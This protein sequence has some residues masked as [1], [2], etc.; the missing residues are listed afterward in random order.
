[1]ENQR[2]TTDT[3]KRDCLYWRDDSLLKGCSVLTRLKCKITR[4]RCSFYKPLN[5]GGKK[6]ED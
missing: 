1:M 2:E 3:I 4:R 5:I 6:D